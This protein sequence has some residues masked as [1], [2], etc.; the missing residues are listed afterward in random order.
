MGQPVVWRRIE[1]LPAL[2]ML[3]VPAFPPTV[4]KCPHGLPETSVPRVCGV[5]W[6]Y[7]HTENLLLS[8]APVRE[9]SLDSQGSQPALVH[10]THALCRRF[11]QADLV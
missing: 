4:P 2:M 3:C 1:A 10:S 5:C 7:R 9:M 8:I 6:G 11:S